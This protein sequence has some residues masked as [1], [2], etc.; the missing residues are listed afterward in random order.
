[1]SAHHYFRDFNYCD[2][3]MNPWLLVAE[4]I[5]KTGL[6]LSAMVSDRIIKY[7]SSGEINR[8][9]IDA[10]HILT[11]IAGKYSKLATKCES[12]DG[13]SLDFDSW[14]FNVRKSNTEPLLRINVESDGDR[15]LMEEK[16]AEI[17][18]LIDRLDSKM[19][20]SLES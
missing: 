1:M 13:L 16:T 4:L 7:P 5:S 9:V 6:S 8:T 3:G 18:I 20:R 11:S 19:S 2:S 14:R 12:I 10:N 15:I 17:L